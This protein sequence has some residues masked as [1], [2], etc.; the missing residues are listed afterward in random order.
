MG[1]LAAGI[2]YV[3]V[4]FAFGRGFSHRPTEQEER[5]LAAAVE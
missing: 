3:V 2:V 4:D 1:M 5:A